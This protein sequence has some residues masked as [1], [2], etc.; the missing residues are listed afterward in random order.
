[1]NDTPDNVRVSAVVARLIKMGELAKLAVP[2]FALPEK[3]AW[4]RDTVL[5]APER[6][7]H[8]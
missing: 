3:G 6:V 4:R 5:P 2:A 7:A 8:G 1:L